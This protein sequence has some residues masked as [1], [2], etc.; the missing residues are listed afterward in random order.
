MDKIIAP[1]RCFFFLYLE[2]NDGDR[3]DVMAREKGFICNERDMEEIPSFCRN[4]MKKEGNRHRKRKK[5]LRHYTYW[6]R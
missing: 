4:V 6:T 3:E 1:T 5:M 2:S